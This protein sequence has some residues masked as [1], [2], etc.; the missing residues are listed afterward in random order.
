MMRSMQKEALNG[1]YLHA[2]PETIIY[3]GPHNENKRLNY[4][5]QTSDRSTET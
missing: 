4:E 3:Y 2:D 5:L 1:R